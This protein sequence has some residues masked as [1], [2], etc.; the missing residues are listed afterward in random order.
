M[1]MIRSVFALA[2]VAAPAVAQPA[3]E[4]APA[5]RLSLE[6]TMQLRCSAAFAII[7]DEQRRDVKSELTYPPLGE[8]GKEFAVRAGARLMDQLQL[9]REAYQA[10]FKAEVESLQ[11]GSI[12]AGDPREYVDAI[13]RP[14]LAALDASGL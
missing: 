5:P 9:S 4:A 8:R 2:L 12:E 7:A 14:C 6:Q 13:M 1:T 10:L 11:R 3:P